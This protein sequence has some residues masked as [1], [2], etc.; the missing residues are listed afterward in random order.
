MAEWI[1]FAVYV[2]LGLAF[3]LYEHRRLKRVL[4]DDYIRARRRPR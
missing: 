2:A 3:W 4:G 1:G